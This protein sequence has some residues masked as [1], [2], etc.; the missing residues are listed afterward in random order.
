MSVFS[1]FEKVPLRSDKS[2]V[3]QDLDF[4]DVRDRPGSLLKVRWNLDIV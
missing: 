2:L 3:E 1:G 4:F